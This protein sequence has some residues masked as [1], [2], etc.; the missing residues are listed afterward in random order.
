MN[1]H[2]KIPAEKN[3]KW[4]TTTA[5]PVRHS[6]HLHHPGKNKDLLKF[7]RSE[8]LD[9]TSYH[10]IAKAEIQ[11]S[12]FRCQMHFIDLWKLPYAF[13]KVIFKTHHFSLALFMH[14]TFPKCLRH[15]YWSLPPRYHMQSWEKEL[16]RAVPKF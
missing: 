4:E 10:F 16:L 1:L 13:I 11:Y 12:L 14:H 15:F 3:R 9:Q 7:N 8:T 2:G 5:F 6:H